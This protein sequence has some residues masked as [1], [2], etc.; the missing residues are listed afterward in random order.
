LIQCRRRAI[1]IQEK[2]P[3]IQHKIEGR[4]TKIRHQEKFCSEF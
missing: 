4:V 1:P 2:P 3:I